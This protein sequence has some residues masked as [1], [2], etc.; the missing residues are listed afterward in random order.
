MTAREPWIP[1]TQKGA[2]ANVVLW[3]FGVAA[4]VLVVGVASW[5]FGWIFAGPKGALEARQQILSGANR[6][7]AYN[8][9]FD[10]CVSVQKLEFASD[11]QQAEL[12][13][14]SGQDDRDRILANIAGITA[15]RAGAVAQYN[16]DAE[17]TYTIGQFR[18]LKLPFQID[19]ASQPSGWQANYTPKGVH[20]TCVA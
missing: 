19:E 12:A 8:H 6:I 4:L 16:A 7:Q 14:A 2:Y 13:A 17:K 15:E 11:A 10:Q 18:D 1:S 3:V 9:F 20:T 5:G